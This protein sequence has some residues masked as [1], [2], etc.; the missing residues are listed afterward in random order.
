MKMKCYP[1]NFCGSD[2]YTVIFRG[3][4]LMEQLPGQFQMVRCKSCGLLRQNPR[5]DWVDLQNYYLPSHGSYKPLLPNSS[6]A[7]TRFI[8]RYGH[9]KR[10]NL[11]SKYVPSGEWLEVGCGSGLILQEAVFRNKWQLR[12]IEPNNQM[13][14][15]VQDSLKIP[16]ST[17]PFEDYS[18]ADESLDVITMWDVLEHLPN[19]ADALKK[20]H[21]LLR[22]G[23][24]FIFQIPNYDSWN[25]AIFK[26][27]W[28]GYDLP[29]HLYLFPKTSLQE[30]LRYSGFNIT[31][32]TCIA[33]SH[34]AL[35]LDLGFWL[36]LN[37]SKLVE[38]IVAKGPE[39]FPFRLIT[40][41]P[42]WITDK[43]GLGSNIT[44]IAKK[45]DEK[46]IVKTF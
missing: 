7:L 8:F 5:L 45:I 30:L 40:S 10:V 27:V 29:R 37:N 38:I 22:D 14:R 15:Y 6:S 41:I 32:Q 2:E 16:V 34:G 33:G 11:V 31:K 17:I 42:L 18:G 3:K 23:G 19:P 36:K 28:G 24:Y 39:F 4:D 43:L 25:R 26:N 1:C 44:I 20:V 46:K 21:K 13:A 12:A 35:I 9:W